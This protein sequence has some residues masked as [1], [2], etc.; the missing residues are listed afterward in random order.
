MENL[1]SRFIF[2]RAFFAAVAA[3]GVA[4]FTAST[5][6]AG[7]LILATAEVPG[8]SGNTS[9]VSVTLNSET[10]SF[11]GGQLWFHFTNSSGTQLPAIQ[12]TV[13][14]PV[15]LPLAPG[16]YS[17][18]ITTAQGSGGSGSPTYPGI[19]VA[20][21]GGG[22]TGGIAPNTYT[23][24]EQVTTGQ[25]PQS[26]VT[27]TQIASGKWTPVPGHSG[28]NT[29]GTTMVPATSVP[30]IRYAASECHNAARMAFKANTS[31][32]N[33]AK[34]CIRNNG[35]NHYTQST[36][37]VVEAIDSFKEIPPPPYN[38]VDGF[39]VTCDGAQV[40]NIVQLGQQLLVVPSL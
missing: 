37:Y 25:V 16:T 12:E 35:F 7:P 11:F 10:Y 15:V 31:W 3:I 14:N 18:T 22:Q 34:V 29:L 36:T 39:A 19:T 4:L 32:S 13:G 20:S 26:G 23:C 40:T 17:L 6:A 8:C 21:C 1:M 5:A 38:R 30:A 33:P 27:S 24:Q 9:N 28:I 2:V